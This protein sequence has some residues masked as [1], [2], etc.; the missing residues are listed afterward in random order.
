MDF[1]HWLAEVRKL[2]VKLGY[3]ASPEAARGW[4]SDEGWKEYF[5]EEY[6]PREAVEEDFSYA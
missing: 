1:E 3:C 6:T 2:L 5:D 4:G